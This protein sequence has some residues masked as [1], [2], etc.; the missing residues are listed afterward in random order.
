MLVALGSTSVS[1]KIFE[2][3]IV[4]GPQGPKNEKT[5]GSYLPKE[6]VYQISAKS[7]NVWAL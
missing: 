2:G 3:P 4:N 7:K 1:C 6:Q 5:P